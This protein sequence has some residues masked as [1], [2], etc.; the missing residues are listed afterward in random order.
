MYEFLA[1]IKLTYTYDTINIHICRVNVQVFF[2]V[3]ILKH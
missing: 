2:C 1:L 3:G